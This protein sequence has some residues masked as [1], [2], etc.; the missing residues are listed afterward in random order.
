MGGGV[1]VSVNDSGVFVGGKSVAVA[2]RGVSLGATAI[3][4]AV[5]GRGVAVGSTCVQPATRS[6]KTHAKTTRLREADMPSIL[7]DY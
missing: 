2:G 3:W 5:G 4:V 7:P 6:R 1:V